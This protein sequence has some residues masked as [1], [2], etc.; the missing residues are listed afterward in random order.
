MSNQKIARF[1]YLLFLE[2]K[3]HDSR[4]ALVGEPGEITVA[5]SRIEDVAASGLPKATKLFAISRM[6]IEAWINQRSN[7]IF[8][9]WRQATKEIT[10]RSLPGLQTAGPAPVFPSKMSL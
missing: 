8:Q 9:R 3:S 1:I 4:S 2:A 5:A 7:Y 10:R 6:Q